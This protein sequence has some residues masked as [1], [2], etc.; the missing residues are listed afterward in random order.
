[1]PSDTHAAM[2]NPR[3]NVGFITNAAGSINAA[4][5]NSPVP[6]NVLRTR[7]GAPPRAIQRSDA[8]PPVSDATATPPN[9][10]RPN[11]AI[12]STQQLLSLTP[13]QGRHVT[14]TNETHP[15]A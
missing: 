5:N 8:Q 3:D 12:C 1:M 14:R 6:A 15:R 9:G 13:D 7:G 11:T 4:H 10:K 2:R